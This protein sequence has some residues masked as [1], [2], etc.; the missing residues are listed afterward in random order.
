MSEFSESYH[1]LCSNYL[2]GI[3]LIK[4]AGLK[5]FVF[6]ESSSWA[7]I[8]LEGS[9]FKPIKKIIESNTGI[10]VHFVNAEDFGWYFSI[11][12]GNKKSCHYECMW[13]DEIEIADEE[14]S[15]DV[16]ESFVQQCNSGTI[17]DKK[18]V[19]GLL[20]PKGVD[21]I[22]NKKPAYRI[23]DLLGLKNYQWV[24]F[25]YVGYDYNGEK[26]RFPDN[27]QVK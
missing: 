7:T 21:T 11:Y 25:E 23:A 6:P 15:M 20:H 12:D 16:F 24:S 3:S 9:D 18:E 19:E 17:V 8:V 27:I 14:F 5:G 13:Q 26:D 10:L 2:D 4:S 22:F 1:L